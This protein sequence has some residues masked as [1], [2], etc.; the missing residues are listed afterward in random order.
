MLSQLSKNM[1]TSN[2]LQGKKILRVPVVPERT[3]Q[4]DPKISGCLKE[5]E[6]DTGPRHL[7]DITHCEWSEEDFG[8]HI[9]C[10]WKCV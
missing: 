10:K 8:E 2:Q 9:C 4:K 5:A 7:E 3:T 1:I 6:K